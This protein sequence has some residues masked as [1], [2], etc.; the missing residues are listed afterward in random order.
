MKKLLV[1]VSVLTS[2][3]TFA[4]ERDSL[5]SNNI[6]EVI[7]NT[8]IKKDTDYTNKMPLKAIE[9]PQ[10]YSSID[11]TVLENQ[12][13]FTVDDAFR[14]VTG[15]QKMWNA[16]GRGGD[17]GAYINLRGFISN[18]SLRNGL[19]APVTSTI[20]ALNIEK[21]EVL[22]GP[23][24]TI[25][26]SNA[27]SYGGVI[28]R[29]TKKP[30][31]TF[32]GNITAAAGSYDYYRVQADVNAP[33]TK[34]KNL[35]FRVNSAY[36]TEGNWQSADA[37]NSYFAFAPSLTWKITDKVDVNIE[38][39][40]FENR[41]L[42]EQNIFFI[43]SP[44]DY[45]Y[46]NMHDIERSGLDYK[47]SYL[48]KNLYNNS[49]SRNL[50]GTVNYKINNNIK[51]TTSVG[52]SYSYSDG[53]NPYFYL[54]TA[55][56]LP[57]GSP[58]GLYRGD[59]STQNSNQ[60]YFQVQQNFNFDFNIGKMRNRLLVGGDY[61]R[62][63]NNQ[64][65]YYGVIDF[66]PYTGGVDYT[67]FNDSYVSAYYDALRA[68]GNF[69][70]STYPIVNKT[71]TYSAYVS[72]VLTLTEGLNVMASI[73]YESNDFKGGVTGINQ[74][75]AY[76]QSAFSPKFGVVYEILKDKFSVFGNYQNSFKSNGY[77]VS[78]ATGRTSLSDPELANQWEGGF[79]TNLI[80]GRVNATLSYYN[81]DVKNTII[82]TTTPVLNESGSPTN[83][84]V[85]NQAGSLTSKG[86]EL[87]LNAYLV[88]GFS[89]IAGVSYN[90]S[91][92][93][94]TDDETTLGR[95][96]NTA[97]SPWLV[98]FN[99]A[100]QF[101]DGRLKGLGFGFGG[102]YASANRIFN[103]TAAVFELPKYLVLNANAFYDTKKFRIGVKVDNFTNEHYWIGYT[104]ANPQ[105]LINAV[106]S[107]TYKF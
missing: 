54:T 64:F 42:A 48:G 68:S 102:N 92:F 86:I 38:Y 97:S 7:I 36:T 6:D 1:S 67:N 79:K 100:Y 65:F 14:N 58:L 82:N 39:E 62:T 55:T 95:R 80:N 69:D 51:S 60:K 101:I 103:T 56:Y 30:F 34:N 53:F 9:N 18:N 33:L 11:K 8:I 94:Q 45:G 12:V 88:K 50:V 3:A 59:Q 4:Q 24:A 57:D 37:Q 44:S 23:S 25:Y 76:N 5:K 46:N 106:G 66:V 104:T 63:N 31:E 16:T 17:G 15:L 84:F 99:A 27:T 74:T 89:V 90:D 105:K 21:V 78:D 29:V 40:M 47:N 107:F 71:D 77:F 35:L 93:T 87:E 52:S 83:N 61:M 2:I 28:N 72:D 98:N 96:P 10:V 73:R 49:R 19:V 22:K 32:A 43:F 81:I 13:I 85:Q 91:K 20:D 75:P 26:G 41:A 70:S